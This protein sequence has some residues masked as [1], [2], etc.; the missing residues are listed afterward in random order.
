MQLREAE[1]PPKGGL[2]AGIRAQPD[3]GR[4]R[5]EAFGLC[6]AD[7]AVRPGDE[8]RDRGALLGQLF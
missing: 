6:G 5:R 2:W 8:G 4:V 1:L 3:R 7:D